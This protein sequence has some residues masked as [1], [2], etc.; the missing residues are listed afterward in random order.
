M[1]N[2]K[3]KSLNLNQG[4]QYWIGMKHTSGTVTEIKDRTIEYEDSIEFVY[5]VYIDGQLAFE[6]INWSVEV[7]YQI[8]DK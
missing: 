4:S 3:I 6:I 5:E 2:R 1:N 7:E 8:E